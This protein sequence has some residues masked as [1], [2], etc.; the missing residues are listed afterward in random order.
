M[1]RMKLDEIINA[2]QPR[3][4]GKHHVCSPTIFWVSPPLLLSFY[5]KIFS[6]RCSS[7]A[8]KDEMGEGSISPVILGVYIVFFLKSWKE[9]IVVALEEEN[10]LT[11]AELLQRFN[12]LPK[13]E[14]SDP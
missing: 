3:L 2:F 12:V 1:P 9:R 14:K 13:R 11:I 6:F 10:K 7:L 4:D 5:S 8:I